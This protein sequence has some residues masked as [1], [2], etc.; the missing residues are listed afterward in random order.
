MSEGLLS[1]SC[2][3]RTKFIN[4]GWMT[5][6]GLMDVKIPAG[7]EWWWNKTVSVLS[8]QTPITVS[9]MVRGG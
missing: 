9:D 3:C 2:L 7:T 8:L 5:S 1:F 4:D 6:E